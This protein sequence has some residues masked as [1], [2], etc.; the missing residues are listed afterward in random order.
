MNKESTF[1]QEGFLSKEHNQNNKIQD[2]NA[3]AFEFLRDI[4][5]MMME[6]SAKFPNTA[7]AKNIVAHALMFRVI[8]SLQ[9]V[10]SLLNIGYRAEVFSIIRTMQESYLF[11]ALHV[12]NEKKLHEILHG[13]EYNFKFKTHS[14]IS[15][16]PEY[17]DYHEIIKETESR[18]RDQMSVEKSYFGYENKAKTAS[19]NAVYNETSTEQNSISIYRDYSFISNTY[20]HVSINSLR[21][22]IL[23][24]KEGTTLLFCPANRGEIWE[25]VMYASKVCASFSGVINEFYLDGSYSEE[26]K[27]LYEYMEIILRENGAIK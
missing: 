18:L 17:S 3:S 21:Q 19:I 10:I 9:A 26:L 7:I 23:E 4:N 11:L 15:N 22:H 25:A 12:K 2:E 24:N 5:I 1:K 16:A 27:Q 8:Q 6:M 14:S 20:C 13:D